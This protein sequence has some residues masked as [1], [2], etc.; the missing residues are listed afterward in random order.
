MALRI[1]DCLDQNLD[2]DI[3]NLDAIL[4]EALIFR[5]MNSHPDPRNANN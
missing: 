5:E 1:K 3:V 2:D 4:I